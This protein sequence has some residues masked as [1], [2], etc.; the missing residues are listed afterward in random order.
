MAP[1]TNPTPVRQG[2]ALNTLTHKVLM[3]IFTITFGLSIYV[4]WH[5]AEHRGLYVWLVLVAFGLVLLNV[6]SRLYALRLQD[7][8]IR[9]EE[10]LRYSRLLSPAQLAK[11][12]DLTL[13]QTIG[14]R[15][16]SDGELSG[17]IERAQAEG[18]T[19]KQIKDAITVWRADLVRV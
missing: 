18:L 5:A 15:F 11:S 4:A 10:Q 7:R 12:Y 1:E 9:L 6:N 8:I 16:A 14:L 17:L 19:Q 13:S 3:P 2:A